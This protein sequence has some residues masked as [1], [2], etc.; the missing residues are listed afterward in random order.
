MLVAGS[1]RSPYNAEAEGKPLKSFEFA[2]SVAAA[3]DICI[4]P[5]GVAPGMG[6]PFFSGTALAL[7]PPLTELSLKMMQSI[8]SSQKDERLFS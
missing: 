5:R 8:K 1:K 3:V 4:N 7:Y 6:R 2:T